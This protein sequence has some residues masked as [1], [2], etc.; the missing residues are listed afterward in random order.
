[1]TALGLAAR[2]VHLAA[3]LSLVGGAAI[4]LLAGRSDRPTARAWFRRVLIWSRVLALVAIASGCV[5][6]AGQTAL[7]EGRSAAVLD[8]EAVRRVVLD[9]QGGR[10]WLVRQG[11]LVL[12]LAF[13]SLRADV[14][15][16]ADWLAARLEAALLAALAA[17]LVGLGGHA[18]AVEP[19]T[20]QA[21]VTD[22]I[23][24][25]AAGVWVGG[26]WP[27]ALLLRRAGTADGADARPYA[28]LTA[29]RFST[30]ALGAVIVLVRDGAGQR[31]RV[32][33]RGGGAPRH[34]ATGTCSS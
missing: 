31:L 13:L 32:R 6:L 24:I 14:R 16:R 10:V 28:V 33:G 30:C 7:L 2:W 27:L 25:L 20:A 26:L 9:T 12:L 8:L 29:R 15:S 4:L 23:H 17:A 21:I 3:G 19:D 11:L 1:M 34:A 5:S 18:A 22:A